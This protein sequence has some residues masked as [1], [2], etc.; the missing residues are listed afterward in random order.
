MN[1]DATMNEEAGPYAGLDRFD[2]R[3]R[4]V[5]DLGREGLLVKTEPHRYAPGRCY[6]CKTLIEPRV[7]EQWFVH[8]KPLAEPAIRAV[9]EGRIRI[10]PKRF[11]KVYFN[12]MENIHDWCISRQLWWGHRIPVW[13]CDECGKLSVTAEESLATCQHCGSANIHQDE[14]VLDTWFSS[15]LWPFST[16]GWPDDTEDMRYFYP[17]TVMETGYDILFFWVARMIMMGLEMTGDIPFRLVYLHGLIRDEYGRKMSKSLGNVIDPLEVIEEYGTDALRFTL[18]TG[19]TPGSDMKLS[20]ERVEAARNFA[21]K[22][23]NAARFV[24]AHIND[25]IP[26]PNRSFLPK[27]RTSRAKSILSGIHVTSVEKNWSLPERWILSRHNRLIKEVTRLIEEYQFGEA[28][29]QIHDFLWG[30]YC[31]WYI[32]I[33]KTRLYGDDEEAKKMAR[34]V[35]LYVLERTMRLLHPF[36]P[37]ITE[38]IWQHLPHEGEAIIVAPWPEAD[39]SLIDEGTEREMELIKEIVHSIR[40]ARAD[41]NVEPSRRIE[42]LIAAGERYELLMEQREVLISLAGLDKEKLTIEPILE[43]KPTKALASVVGPVEIYLPLAGMVD[44]ER[45]RERLKKEI[46]RIEAEL[47]RAEELLADEEFL[48]KAPPKV[49]ER[50]REKLAD[51]KGRLEKLEGRLQSLD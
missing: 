11:E 40:S 5:E 37:F 13:S 18:L 32:E 22:I 2:C 8:T 7:S 51:Y 24:L 25:Q 27:S 14:D 31:D 1:E 48:K 10:I 43:E 36:M 21:N 9:R 20:L 39:E 4:L 17:T 34:R 16:L 30:E 44:L 42:A 3:Q 35:L 28:G 33:S 12:W 26:N 45:E 6:R 15:A 29:R 41:Y 38:E 49:V 47:A 23:W 19:S 50:E 46:A